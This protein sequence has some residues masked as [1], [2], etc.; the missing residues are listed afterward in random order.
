LHRKSAG[1]KPADSPA[2]G[3]REFA[4]YLLFLAYGCF[5]YGR[6]WPKKYQEKGLTMER[7]SESKRLSGWLLGVVVI[8]AALLL[9]ACDQPSGQSGLANKPPPNLGAISNVDGSED[10][11]KEEKKTQAGAEQKPAESQ[12]AGQPAQAAPKQ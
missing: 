4:C 6:I 1:S 8:G 3:N 10:S 12:A 2:T 5:I 9:F 7:R 11:K